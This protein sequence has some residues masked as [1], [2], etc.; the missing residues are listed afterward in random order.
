MSLSRILSPC[1]SCVF[2]SLSFMQVSFLS[3]RA[4]ALRPSHQIVHEGNDVGL[5]AAARAER[6]PLE[7]P[8]CV[9]GKDGAFALKVG[10]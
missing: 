9:V 6:A 2:F 4:A 7:R 1:V 8:N 3:L 5:A 10:G